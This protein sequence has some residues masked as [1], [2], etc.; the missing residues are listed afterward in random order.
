MSLRHGEPL[1]ILGESGYFAIYPGISE[2]IPNITS[3]NVIITNYAELAKRFECIWRVTEPNGTRIRV[4]VMEFVGYRVH[5]T[6]GNGIEP[7]NGVPVLVIDTRSQIVS[8]PTETLSIDSGVWITLT[9]TRTNGYWK[10]LRLVFTTYQEAGKMGSLYYHCLFAV[11]TLC[12][13]T[14]MHSIIDLS[15]CKQKGFACELNW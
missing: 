15:F 10:K 12:I 11:I 9:Y 2:T 4:E 5:L 14:H 7:T 8:L 13:L 3:D 1:T 6:I